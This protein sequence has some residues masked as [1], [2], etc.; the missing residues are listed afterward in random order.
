MHHALSPSLSDHEWEGLAL[1]FGVL[2]FHQYLHGCPFI[3]V[4]DHR[5]LCK[6]FGNKQGIPPMAAARMQRWA[7]T[8]SAYQY[9]IE[10][11]S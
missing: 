9:T 5:L 2:C 8:F 4:T 7:L 3:L 1:V 10:W 6:I 11:Y